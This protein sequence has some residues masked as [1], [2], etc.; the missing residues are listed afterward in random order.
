MTYE[1]AEELSRKWKEKGNP[2]CDHSEIDREYMY[3]AHSDYVCTTCGTR[4]FNK[5]DFHK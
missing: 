3:G 4:R 5:A 2:P 1:E